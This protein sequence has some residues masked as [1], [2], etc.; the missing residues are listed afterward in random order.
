MADGQG[1][2]C[3]TAWGDAVKQ[4]FDAF[5]LPKKATNCRGNN[6]AQPIHDTECSKGSRLLL[7]SAGLPKVCFA[8]A[9]VRVEQ[10]TEHPTALTPS[11][12]P[13]C[14]G[15]AVVAL[16]V[17]CDICDFALQNASPA[18]HSNLVGRRKAKDQIG[19]ASS[20]SAS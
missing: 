5:A 12:R 3:S 16:P 7:F 8:D 13:S 14:A 20:Q 10:P 15:A 9:S 1:V 4:Y 18:K 11:V 17:C 19:T 2:T 6:R